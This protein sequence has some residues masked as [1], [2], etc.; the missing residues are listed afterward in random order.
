MRLSLGQR[1]SSAFRRMC[2]FF[3]CGRRAYHSRV[4]IAV[5]AMK[6]RS[7]LLL[8]SRDLK[9]KIGKIGSSHTALTCLIFS[10]RAPLARMALEVNLVAFLD[11]IKNRQAQQPSAADQSEVQKPETAKE[12]DSREAVQDQGAPKPMQQMPP[13]QQAKVE[14]IKAKLQS[15]TQHLGQDASSTSPAPADSTSSPQPMAQKMTNQDKAAPALSPTS[16]QAGISPSQENAP[17]QETPAKTQE[18]SGRQQTMART[19][20]SWER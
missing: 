3:S 4:A 6:S 1:N 20:P 5:A 15:A 11:F 18:P 19:T 9:Q 14:Q 16:A 7:D 13:D 10:S 12:M 2:Q 8:H 17:S